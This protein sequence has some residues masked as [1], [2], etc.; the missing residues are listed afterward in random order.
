M[1]FSLRSLFVIVTIVALIG[2][3]VGWFRHLHYVQIRKLNAVLAEYPQIDKVWLITN[4]DVTLEVEQVYF[5]IAGEPGLI[6]KCGGIDHVG[7]LVFKNRLE[8]A[9]RRMRP[10]TLPNYATEHRH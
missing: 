3:F 1:R 8:A 10:V 7:P 2:G 6:F 4:D 9:L 5:S